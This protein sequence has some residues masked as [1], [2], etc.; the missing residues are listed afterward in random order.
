MHELTHTHPLTGD[1]YLSPSHEQLL[2]T[3]MHDHGYGVRVPRSG[4]GGDPG[5][6]PG[7]YGERVVRTWDLG[8][9]KVGGEGKGEGEHSRPRV[10]RSRVEKVPYVT[11]L[12]RGEAWGNA[13]S[14]VYF[15]FVAWGG[16][17]DPSIFTGGKIRRPGSPGRE[18]RGERLRRIASETRMGGV[19]K[20]LGGSNPRAG[21]FS[22]DVCA[23]GKEPVV[24]ILKG[25]GH[26]GGT[27]RGRGRGRG[28]KELRRVFC[29]VKEEA[30][31]EAGLS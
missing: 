4:E 6:L 25:N 19:Q 20:V 31:A 18:T 3:G 1:L 15:G 10:L 28:R 2:T 9:G 16:M 26:G 24:E 17:A 14:L 8:G 11:E 23:A 29:G 7:S 5:R 12:T 21:G 13:D 30:K 22:P 27:R